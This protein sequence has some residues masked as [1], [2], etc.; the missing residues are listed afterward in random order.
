VGKVG[1]LLSTYNGSKYLEELLNSLFAQTYKNFLIYIR[2]DGSS[3]NTCKILSKYKKLFN[4]KISC[5]KNVG[6]KRSFYFLLQQ[7]LKDDIDYFMFCDQDDVWKNDKLEVFLKY[8]YLDKPL[9]LH[10]DLIVV[11]ENLKVIS[12]S[13]WQYQLIN[14]SF[15]SLQHLL[16]SNIV[17]GCASMFNRKLAELVKY[18]PDMIMHDWWIALIGAVFGKISYIDY[19]TV[20]YRQ[21][22]EN[23]VG[24]TN[25]RNISYILSKL[26]AKYL[27]DDI[28]KQAESFYYLYNDIM[29]DD[30]KY[31]FEKFLNIKGNNF[32]LKKINLIRYGFLKGNFLK[33]LFFLMK[34]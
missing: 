15:N 29:E 13:F 33:D 26:F 2:D 32:L 4:V 18:S 5:S 25:F 34:V 11:D 7:A 10:S 23:I 27:Y 28:F 19:P 6:V 9:L 30:K 16:V 24:A 3:D 12:S 22:S 21:H 31:I 8:A 14:P 20:F 17:T 1:I